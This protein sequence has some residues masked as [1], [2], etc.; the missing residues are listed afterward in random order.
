MFKV[1]SKR[2]EIV[3]TVKASSELDSYRSVLRLNL[4]K[5]CDEQIDHP[6]R[7][8]KDDKQ[9]E[10]ETYSSGFNALLRLEQ[11]QVRNK[12]FIKRQQS[13][14]VLRTTIAEH[15]LNPATKSSEERSDSITRPDKARIDRLIALL[16]HEKPINIPQMVD[17]FMKE[18]ALFLMAAEQVLDT[19]NQTAVKVATMIDYLSSQTYFDTVGHIARLPFRRDITL[20][21]Y[22]REK[23]AGQAAVNAPAL[24]LD[25]DTPAVDKDEHVEQVDTRAN[26]Y[27]LGLTEQA[28]RLKQEEMLFHRKN[29]ARSF[30]EINEDIVL[31]PN[32]FTD[33]FKN[34]MSSDIRTTTDKLKFAQDYQYRVQSLDT[35]FKWLAKAFFDMLQESSTD[36][37][38]LTDP[39]EFL[40][41]LHMPRPKNVTEAKNLLHYDVRLF[42]I[43]VD[44]ILDENSDRSV[45]LATAIYALSQGTHLP[46]EHNVPIMPKSDFTSLENLYESVEPLDKGSSETEGYQ[47]YSYLSQ[48][49]LFTF[50]TAEKMLLFHYT[51][52]AL[53]AAIGMYSIL[54]L[55]VLGFLIDGS[56]SQPERTPFSYAA[57]LTLTLLWAFSSTAEENAEPEYPVTAAL[58]L[59]ALYAYN[60]AFHSPQP[61]ISA[62]RSSLMLNHMMTLIYL[63][64]D[65]VV[66]SEASQDIGYQDMI[67]AIHTVILMA[68]LLDALALGWN[69]PKSV[70]DS[71]EYRLRLALEAGEKASLYQ[72]ATN[73]LEPNFH[74]F[75]PAISMLIPIVAEHFSKHRDRSEWTLAI[76]PVLLGSYW[77]NGTLGISTILPLFIMNQWLFPM[78]RPDRAAT[79]SKAMA[80][81]TLFFALYSAA[82]MDQL[83]MDAPHFAT[84]IYMM[85]Q[86]QQFTPGFDVTLA[87]LESLLL[88]YDKDFIQQMPALFPSAL[89]KAL[90]DAEDVRKKLGLEDAPHLDL[91]LDSM[92]RKTLRMPSERVRLYFLILS[93]LR[94][95]EYI[96][97]Q[98]PTLNTLYR[99]IQLANLSLLGVKLLNYTRQNHLDPYLKNLDDAKTL[100]QLSQ[101]CF[102][103]Y[104]E[105]CPELLQKA[106]VDG[107]LTH[108]RLPE[109]WYDADGELA[110]PQHLG[111]YQAPSLIPVLIQLHAAEGHNPLLTNSSLLDFCDEQYF[112]DNSAQIFYRTVWPQL[113]LSKEQTLNTLRELKRQTH[114]DYVHKQQLKH[115]ERPTG[116]PKILEKAHKF[117]RD[118]AKLVRDDTKAQYSSDA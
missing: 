36:T 79:M 5:L 85:S 40:A 115:P 70:K 118:L 91:Y 73:A 9:T 26:D 114:A 6:N 49:A 19:N 15:L 84:A 62:L 104:S 56:N 96:L 106:L 45:Q 113:G 63:L 44:T 71:T 37:P 80:N 17:L 4:Q 57:P 30:E 50:E 94:R 108:H 13:L 58:G 109:G 22:G 76:T 39:S 10:K 69:P 86:I 77:A 87:T 75:S 95:T 14:D 12:A 46:V 68:P 29:G 20:R 92:N 11:G 107:Q 54:I 60:L 7:S 8:F 33:G 61:K 64:S 28:S 111:F 78:S 81:P 41:R 100:E 65:S 51:Y 43:T 89:P 53:S 101:A 112:N 52:Q 82:F 72:L 117:F 42:W 90:A 83:G 88:K 34:L 21:Q 25:H 74:S 110:I 105:D 3:F 18:P 23:L 27:R 38:K 1:I 103:E 67:T 66:G 102:D 93:D 59:S 24:T 47:R 16:G 35:L 98:S 99:Y 97:Q 32:Q 116:N 2:T 55:F 31:A 48:M